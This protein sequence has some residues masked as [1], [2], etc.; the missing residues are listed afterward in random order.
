MT[1]VSVT[2]ASYHCRGS[3][4]GTVGEMFHKKLRMMGAIEIVE[5]RAVGMGACCV[6]V[7]LVSSQ[8]RWG[9]RYEIGWDSWMK[10]M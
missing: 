8:S 4:L 3:V 7:T 6:T 9:S 1:A 5:G 10:I 2:Y